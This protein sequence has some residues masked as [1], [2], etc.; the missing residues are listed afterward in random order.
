MNRLIQ[1]LT[2]GTIL[3]LSAAAGV[4]AAHAAPPAKNAPA[5]AATPAKTAA[6]AKEHVLGTV[7]AVSAKDHTMTIKTDGGDR[8]YSV[9][10]NA[11]FTREGKSVAFGTV[12]TGEHIDAQLMKANGKDLVV[13]GVISA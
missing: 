10:P 8:V 6:P 9:A 2:L 3:T 5:K 4:A 11:A 13:R 7:A 1:S 12:K